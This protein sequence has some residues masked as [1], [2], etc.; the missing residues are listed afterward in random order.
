MVTRL[1][2]WKL[3]APWWRWTR[4]AHPADGRDTA[5]ALQKL[6]G[7]DFVEQFLADPQRSL[8]FDPQV[9]V[10]SRLDAAGVATGWMGRLVSRANATREDRLFEGP[11]ELPYWFKAKAETRDAPSFLR[12]LFLPAHDRHYFVVCEL[13]CDLPGLPG[14]DRAQVCQAGFVVRRRV[15]SIP[16]ELEDEAG[17]RATLLATAE[18]DLA[19]LE[20]LAEDAAPAELHI[21]GDR[22]RRSDEAQARAD[23]REALRREAGA[24]DWQA[25]LAAE[26]AK[27]DE[28]RRELGQWF[29]DEGL[30]SATQGWIPGKGWVALSAVQPIADSIHSLGEHYFPLTPLVPDPR[31]PRHDAAGR[32]IYFGVVPTVLADHDAQR[33]PRFDSSSTYEIRCFVRRHDEKMPRRSPGAPDCCGEVVWS[34]PT[35]PFRIAP[36]FDLIGTAQRPITIHMPDL[37]ELAAQVRKRPR[38]RLSPVAFVQP[39]HLSPKLTAMVPQPGAPGGPAMCFFAIPLI[40]IVALFLLNIFLP[41]V[42]YLFQLWHL[43]ALTF[44]IKPQIPAVNLDAILA[45]LPPGVDPTGDGTASKDELAIRVRDGM[46]GQMGADRPS[47]DTLK[48]SSVEDLTALAQA[49]AD[50]AALPE[51]LPADA[52]RPGAEALAYVARREA[53]WTLASVRGA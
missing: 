32:T 52:P 5:P 24:R 44:C 14:V 50:N 37:M 45:A 6:A 10:V 49:Q 18:A 11:K 27:V 39:Q 53:Q 3:V 46:E 19:V 29:A 20:E 21:E 34:R 23:R 42:V 12:K 40:T 43:L 7:D 30:D 22:L 35:E 28:K 33:K 1:H 2:E 8:V 16:K 41:I 48:G 47:K 51:E 17:V 38:R 25:Y 36:P 15:V 13:H 4:A 31:Q 9:D 26:R